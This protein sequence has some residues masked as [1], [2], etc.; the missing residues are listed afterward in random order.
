MSSLKKD[1]NTISRGIK[2]LPEFLGRGYIPLSAA[3]T[4]INRMTP[5]IAIHASGKIITALS[6]NRSFGEIF[7][8]ALTAILLTFIFDTI[9]K[10]FGKLMRQRQRQA[11][12][13]H[14][15][16]MSRKALTLNYGQAE[17]SKI[18]EL[19]AKVQ[20]NSRGG[21]GGVIWL[22]SIFPELISYIISAVV[23][24]TMISGMFI[25]H[26]DRELTGLL[27]FADSNQAVV[28]LIV[29]IA[30]LVIVSVISEKHGADSRFRRFSSRGK[31]HATMDYYSE[32]V[33][34]ENESGKDIRIFGEKN[35]I[36]EELIS[37]VFK[38][39]ADSENQVFKIQATYGIAKTASIDIIGGLVY[40][41]VGLKALAGAFDAG[42]VVEYFGMI[43]A[44]ISCISDIA[45]DITLIKSNN[46]YLELELEYLSLT[47]DVEDGTRE[48]S[49]IDTQN[50]EFEFHNVSF[51]YPDTEPLVL[52]NLSMKIKAGERLAV[53]G[54]NG[55]GKSTMIKLL[56][57]LYEPT[58]GYITVNG[59]D[60]SEFKYTEYL[61]LFSVVFQ[62]FKLLAFPI[63]EN[64]AI[65]EEYDTEKVWSCLEAA[66]IKDRVQKMPRQLG[67]PI[68]KLY[69]KDGMD[70][71][72]GEEQKVA[73]ARALFKKAPFVILDE[74][75]AALDPI[76][77]SEIYARFNTMVNDK[78]AVY[79][80]H[81]L[82]SCRF[83][84]RIIVFDKGEIIEEG[85]H[86]ELTALDGKYNEMWNA[87]AQYYR[88]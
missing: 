41:F 85:T 54:M 2:Q 65:S 1:I 55:S 64:V 33:L 26:S 73:I 49:E 60:I 38:P 10:I 3:Q 74:P 17:S 12:P 36:T 28:L 18:S 11:R 39:F 4:A 53:V 40:L 34:N 52:K 66:G 82:S 24:F 80:S 5:Y 57:R 67:Q 48:T 70:I 22:S 62:D 35:L 42:K 6:Q 47:S 19:R 37:R 45:H 30:A 69:E 72:G 79:I 44:L 58:D 61:K 50:A 88:N 78:T 43:I 51:R 32:K 7:N 76:A 71:S 83:C 9:C 8:Y 87:Q 13:K 16:I 23:A 75:T 21:R 15:A 14:D 81:R 77:E 31:L 63:G 59:V 27:K 20:E 68:Y 84:D 56:C 86:E 25:T 29:I 46:N